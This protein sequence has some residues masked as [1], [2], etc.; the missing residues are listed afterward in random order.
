MRR[1]LTRQLCQAALASRRDERTLGLGCWV[2]NKS[3]V[4]RFSSTCYRNRLSFTASESLSMQ[5]NQLKPNTKAMMGVEWHH[6]KTMMGFEWHHTARTAGEKLI[7]PLDSHRDKW[8]ASQRSLREI[9]PQGNAL[10][11][12]SYCWARPPFSQNSYQWRDTAPS[13]HISEVPTP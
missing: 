3:Y 7:C 11:H 2:G 1:R 8:T 5:I 13:T 12:V 9:I 6:T 10:G 4:S